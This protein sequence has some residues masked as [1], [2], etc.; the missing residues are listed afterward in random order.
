LSKTQLIGSLK[1]KNLKLKKKEKRKKASSLCVITLITIV[2][3]NAIVALIDRLI[4]GF[5][6]LWT[7]LA[8]H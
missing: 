2:T 6:G 8:D 7:A 5:V 4:G 3:T 1:Y